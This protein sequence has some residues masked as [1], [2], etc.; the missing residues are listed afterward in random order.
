MVRMLTYA[1]AARAWLAAA[2]AL[3]A[4][5]A[6]AVPA[7]ANVPLTRISSDPFDNA[8]SQHATEVEPDSFSFGS[9]IVSAFQQGRFTDGGSTDI[10]FSTS[11]DGGA[12]WHAGSLPGITTFVGGRFS[13]VSD[14]AV[15][16]D[17]RHGVWLI[18][19][20]PLLGTSGAG[21]I[22]SRSTNGGLAWGSPV[23]VSAASGTDKTWIACDNTS[24]SPFF[25]HCYVEF[26]NNAQGNLIQMSTSADGGATW[27][28]SLPTANR[29]A[30]IGGQPVVQPSGTVV[31]PIDNANETAVGA[32]RSTDGG[33]SWTGVTTIALIHAHTE[34]GNLRSGPLPSAE[35]DGAGRVY[36]AWG[37][38]RFRRGCRA[39]DIVLSSSANGTTWTAV[40]RVPIDGT[41][42]G[43]DHFLPGLAVDRST[44]GGTAHLGLSYYFYPVSRCTQATCSLDA[45]FISSTNGGATWGSA[46]QLA[47]PMK[48]TSLASTTQGFMVGDYFSTSFANG[49]AHPVL[50]VARPPVGS[51]FDEAMHT[52]ATGLRAPLA[53][54]AGEVAAAE[55]VPAGINA[56]NHGDAR[57]AH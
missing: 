37:D 12:T 17:A 48:V 46:T 26:D 16:F 32:F 6:G 56:V 15:A 51:R 55:P 50:A 36:V 41:R 2:A 7:L 3:T 14:P 43:V 18:A 10:G 52:P 19:S 13:R 4:A 39:N 40:S 44:S 23:V 28:P 35:L 33:A 54:T 1:R 20:L 49:T 11:T 57:T 24:T 25:G 8:T 30:G 22:V 45:G 53:G 5:V 34:A 47:G 42:S 21:A 31:V 27:G 29:E 38:C 9:T